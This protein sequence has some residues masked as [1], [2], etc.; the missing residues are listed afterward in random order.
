MGVYEFSPAAL[1]SQI[2][3]MHAHGNMLWFTMAAM[4]AMQP[5]AGLNQSGLEELAQA[6]ITNWPTN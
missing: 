5:S 4:L 2:F 1:Q 3:D 6:L